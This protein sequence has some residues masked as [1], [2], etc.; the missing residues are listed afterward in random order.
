[1]ARG[2]SLAPL[3]RRAHSPARL[4]HQVTHLRA[5]ARV[6]VGSPQGSV[7][8]HPPRAGQGVAAPGPPEKG[9]PPSS[10]RRVRHPRTWR[11][12]AGPL[13]VQP[14][15]A[16][17]VAAT[18]TSPRVCAAAGCWLTSG[19]NGVPPGGGRPRGGA[20]PAWARTVAFCLSA[21]GRP[22]LQTPLPTPSLGIAPPVNG[23]GGAEGGRG[24]PPM[25]APRWLARRAAPHKGQAGQSPFGPRRTKRKASDG[26]HGNC[27][28]ARGLRRVTPPLRRV[29]RPRSS[30]RAAVIF[31]SAA[32]TQ[33]CLA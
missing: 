25:M 2:C 15:V 11:P 4:G 3:P 32:A 6:V 27:E 23:Q 31:R 18:V 30:P 20:P 19:W 10:S 14:A 33:A 9:S 21:P 17:A 16:V 1:M 28:R 26:C 29:L 12:L 24:A 8:T 22:P 5:H 7:D 13:L